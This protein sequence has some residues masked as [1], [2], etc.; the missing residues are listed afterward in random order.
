MQIGIFTEYTQKQ[1]CRVHPPARLRFRATKMNP[2]LHSKIEKS[3]RF[4][5][6]W[7]ESRLDPIAS[8][9]QLYAP[10]GHTYLFEIFGIFHFKI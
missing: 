5:R 2:D 1:I 9:V 10:Q 8:L 7:K 3:H 4:Q 6:K